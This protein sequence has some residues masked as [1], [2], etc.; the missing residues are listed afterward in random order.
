MANCRLVAGLRTRRLPCQL[1]EHLAVR[2]GGVEG[3][4]WGRPLVGPPCGGAGTLVVGD[5]IGKEPHTPNAAERHDQAPL[6]RVDACS[7]VNLSESR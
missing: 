5:A 3:A 6:K 4:P 7:K 1:G 2:L